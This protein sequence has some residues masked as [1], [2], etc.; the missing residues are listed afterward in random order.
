MKKTVGV[1]FMTICMILF[2][3]IPVNAVGFSEN[4]ENSDCWLNI[5]VQEFTSTEEFQSY[6]ENIPTAYADKTTIKAGVIRSGD[7]VE[8]E[9]YLYWSGTYHISALKYG[10]IEVQTGDIPIQIL[11]TFG[12]SFYETTLN[13]GTITNSGNVKVGD[14]EIPTDRTAVRVR[15]SSLKAYVHSGSTASWVSAILNNSY[16]TIN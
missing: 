4:P 7:T 2:F 6:L 14:L 3:C 16:P 9:L 5:P 13:A 15:A 8:C 1:F 10:V 11:E 12:S